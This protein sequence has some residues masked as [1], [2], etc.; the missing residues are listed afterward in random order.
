[1]KAFLYTVIFMFTWMPFHSIG[2][3]LF[4]NQI[5]P[6]TSD[7]CSSFPDGIPLVE[8]NKWQM[9]CVQHDIAYWQGGTAE[10]RKMADQEL[11]ACV[12]QTGESGIAFA[13]YLGV[14][15]GGYVGLPTSWRWGYGWMLE[16]GYRPLNSYETSLVQS[17]LQN[18]PA[19]LDEVELIS[20]SMMPTRESLTGDYCKDIAVLQ[21]SQHLNRPFEIEDEETRIKEG[22]QGWWKTLRIKTPDCQNSFEFTFLLLK[23]NACEPSANEF[24]ARGRIR[25][26][27]TKTPGNC[28]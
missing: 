20:P 5:L 18:I 16:R 24:L 19:I 6:F 8:A 9:C 26:M 12:E 27:K 13:M 15:M 21:I 3:E 7:G 28:L 22:A 1:M 14:R 23:P 25:L 10:Q 17:E 4:S 2:G 11:S